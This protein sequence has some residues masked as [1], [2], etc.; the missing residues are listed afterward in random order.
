MGPGIR[1]GRAVLL[2]LIIL[3]LA[4]SIRAQPGHL[5]WPDAIAPL[6][7]ERSHAEVCA[8]LLKRHGD[9]PQIARG[10]LAYG[11][12]KSE[13]DAVI[14]G[15]ITALATGHTPESLPALQARLET[16]GSLLDDFCNSVSDIL[17]TK[18]PPGQRDF[19]SA[20]AKIG[21][22]DSLVKAASDGVAALYNNYRSDTLLTRKTIQ[23]QLEAA[24]WPAFSEVKA[25]Q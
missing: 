16:G 15:L 5:T 23:T 19:W 17:S 7:K 18:I 12:A 2:S 21:G 8:A 10:E 24:R 1:R 4:D 20:L 13:S 6:A 14:A 11:K 22:I 9:P 25:A 3:L